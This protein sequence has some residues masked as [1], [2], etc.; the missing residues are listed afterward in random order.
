MN[1]FRLRVIALKLKYL[2]D[3]IKSHY[4]NNCYPS[5]PLLSDSQLESFSMITFS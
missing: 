1:L 5:I 3:N 4:E 2:S